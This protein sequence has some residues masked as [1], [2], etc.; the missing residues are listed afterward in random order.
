MT[1]DLI[2]NMLT[3]IRNASK[4]LHLF[5][6]C[7]YSKL[8]LNILNILITENYIKNYKILNNNSSIKI[9]LKYKGWWIKK[10]TFFLL[11]KISKSG[12]R[13]FSNY[14]QLPKNINI[15]N[16]SKGIAILSTSSGLMTHHK[17]KKLKKGG[18]ILCYIE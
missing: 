9:F 4:V 17:A 11:K 5:T 2:A 14:K 13:I 10:P 7:Q 8:N 3:N 12:K 15:L 16:Y 6:F 1:N 18:E